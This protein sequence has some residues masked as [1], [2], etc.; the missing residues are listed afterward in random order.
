MVL[1]GINLCS[2][3]CSLVGMKRKPRAELPGYIAEAL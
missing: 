2:S 3:V 1:E